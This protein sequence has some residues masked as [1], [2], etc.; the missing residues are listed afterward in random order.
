[1]FIG[2]EIKHTKNKTEETDELIGVYGKLLLK[3]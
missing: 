2:T 3:I 1:M